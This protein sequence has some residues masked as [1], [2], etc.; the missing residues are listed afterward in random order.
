MTNNIGE[1]ADAAAGLQAT[2]AEVEL[3]TRCREGCKLPIQLNCTADGY[4]CRDAQVML[5]LMTGRPNILEA[6]PESEL[7]DYAKTFAVD[8]DAGYFQADQLL[9]NVVVTGDYLV[10]ND[11]SVALPEYLPL[12]VLYDPRELLEAGQRHA[13][14]LLLLPLAGGGSVAYYRSDQVSFTVE[15]Q[16]YKKFSGRCSLALSSCSH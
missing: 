13:N 14:F 16:E 6:P 10:S 8:F 5:Q 1:T 2:D 7:L 12:L 4:V 9:Q 15:S 3:L 11:F